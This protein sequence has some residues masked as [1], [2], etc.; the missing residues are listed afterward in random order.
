MRLLLRVGRWPGWSRASR[1]ETLFALASGYTMLAITFL[2][3]TPVLV[4]LAD[5]TATRE[6]GVGQEN[7]HNAHGL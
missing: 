5:G 1:G 6:W 3:R 2:A 4:V 7:T